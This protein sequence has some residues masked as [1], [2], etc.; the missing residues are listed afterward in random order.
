L[1]SAPPDAP[2][3]PARPTF[4]IALEEQLG[5]KLPLDVIVIDSIE[6]PVAD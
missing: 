1:G 3:D 6:Q 5:L 4:L 2:S